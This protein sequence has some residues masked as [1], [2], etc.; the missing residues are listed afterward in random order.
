[1]KGTR[2]GTHQR[3]IRED[4][5]SR[6]HPLPFSGTLPY[7]HYLSPQLS[8]TS[9]RVP[10][11][12]PLTPVYPDPLLIGERL[13]V[14]RVDI[15]PFSLSGR[16]NPNRR[17]PYTTDPVLFTSSFSPIILSG[18]TPEEVRRP[19]YVPVTSPSLPKILEGTPNIGC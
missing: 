4:E 18:S 11:W 15:V 14:K 12:I 16:E 19:R 10:S 17:P 9:C 7:T 5:D 8:T 6:N 1:M 2:G 3:M 13:G